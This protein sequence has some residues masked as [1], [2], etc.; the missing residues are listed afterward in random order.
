MRKCSSAPLL[1]LSLIAFVVAGCDSDSGEEESVAGTYALTRL[2]GEAMPGILSRIPDA[3]GL[4][5]TLVGELTSGSL[6]L[7]EGGSFQAQT[8][9]RTY[10]EPS[11]ETISTQ[12]TSSGGS[13]T[14]TGNTIRFSG[15]GRASTGTIDG[16]MLAVEQ[17]INVA[18]DRTRVTARYEKE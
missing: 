17:V 10:C 12:E 3:C 1:A 18:G 5:N 15:E 9:T 14:V 6:T 2:N 7:K 13:Y 8:A 4:G 16:E 11:G